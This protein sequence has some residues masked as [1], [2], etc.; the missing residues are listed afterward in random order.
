MTNQNFKPTAC[1]ICYA[2]CGVIV[3]LDETGRQIVKVRG[4]KSHPVSRG[5]IC[6]KAARLNYYQNGRDR[7][8]SPLRRKDD[9]SFEP[10]D[11]D[12]AIKEIAD[13]FSRIRESYGG[14]KIMYYGGGGQ[15]NHLGGSY[16]GSVQK[17]LGM[18]Y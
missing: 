13:E 8:A 3:Q 7:L 2:N 17:A 16:S 11:W 9:G 1:N 12:T 5:Y 14:D 18:K 4:D 6:N 10:V 15:G